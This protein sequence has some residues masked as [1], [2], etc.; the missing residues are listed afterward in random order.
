[1]RSTRFVEFDW[2]DEQCSQLSDET[3]GELDLSIDFALKSNE[4]SEHRLERFSLYQITFFGFGAK[5]TDHRSTFIH[6][7]FN[8]LG[9]RSRTR[10]LNWKSAWTLQATTNKLFELNRFS[11]LTASLLQTTR[12]RRNKFPSWGFLFEKILVRRVVCRVRQDFRRNR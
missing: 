3:T 11:F 8:V 5:R 4:Q 2:S 12:I 10:K 6:W 9:R 1:M 7:F